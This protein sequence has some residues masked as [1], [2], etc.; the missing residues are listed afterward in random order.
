M[1]GGRT[2]VEVGR[3]CRLSGSDESIDDANRD[4]CGSVSWG[5][6][7]DAARLQPCLELHARRSISHLQLLGA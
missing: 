3:V 7:E 1:G 6:E 5:A 4:L 2:G